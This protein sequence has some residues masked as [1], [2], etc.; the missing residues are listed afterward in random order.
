MLLLQLQQDKII[1]DGLK[2][3]I[4]VNKTNLKELLVKLQMSL[5][6][7]DANTQKQRN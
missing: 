4:F 5:L 1:Q 3:Q 6:T 2:A 7:Q